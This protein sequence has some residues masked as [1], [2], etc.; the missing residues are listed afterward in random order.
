MIKRIGKLLSW[1]FFELLERFAFA[2]TVVF[3]LLLGWML[4]NPIATQVFGIHARWLRPWTM[5]SNTGVGIYDVQFFRLETG[6]RSPVT[7]TPPASEFARSALF[8][9]P[10]ERTL[11]TPKRLRAVIEQ[12]CA[13]PAPEEIRAVIRRGTR[14]GWETKVTPDVALCRETLD[15]E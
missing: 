7:W 5:F 6:G 12:V 4:L 8:S 11:R 1:D 13:L 2:R 10:I 15:V 9:D 3:F 14:H